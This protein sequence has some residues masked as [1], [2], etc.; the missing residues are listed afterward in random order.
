MEKQ[1]L[2]QALMRRTIIA[3]VGQI[4]VIGD[5]RPWVR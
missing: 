1:E 4:G 2:E 3:Q 5:I